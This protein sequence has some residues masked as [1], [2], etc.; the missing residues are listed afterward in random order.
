MSDQQVDAHDLVFATLTKTPETRLSP[1]Q[2]LRYSILNH[3]AS[4]DRAYNKFFNAI[5]FSSI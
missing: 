1:T 3:F 5:K 2:D 4:L